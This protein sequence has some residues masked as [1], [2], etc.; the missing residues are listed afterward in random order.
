MIDWLIDWLIDLGVVVGPDD[1]S[2]AVVVTLQ[3]HQNIVCDHGVDLYHVALHRRE[4]V[5]TVTE[6]ALA[7]PNAHAQQIMQ[8][9]PVGAADLLRPGATWWIG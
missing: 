5:S 8:N 6:A 1:G 4:L 7:E 3:I 9:K 2:H